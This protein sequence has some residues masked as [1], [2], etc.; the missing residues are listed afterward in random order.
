M[1]TAQGD[2]VRCHVVIR[3]TK[4]STVRDRRTS[5]PKALQ[6]LVPRTLSVIGITSIQGFKVQDLTSLIPDIF[7]SHTHSHIHL[8]PLIYLQSKQTSD[9]KMPGYIVC[10]KL[11]THFTFAYMFTKVTL[12]PDTSDEDVKACVRR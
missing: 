7:P 1:T 8:Y 9:F 12:K 6:G 2:R 4:A 5:S 10:L 11:L 3:R